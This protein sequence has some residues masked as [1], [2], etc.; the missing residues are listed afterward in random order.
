MNT[1]ATIQTM[2][3]MMTASKANGQ[4]SALMGNVKGNEAAP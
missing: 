4:P 3:L 1:P 2:T